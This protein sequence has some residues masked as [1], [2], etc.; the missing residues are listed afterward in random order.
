MSNGRDCDATRRPSHAPW[1]GDDV[2]RLEEGIGIVKG[3]AH[4]HKDQIGEPGTFGNGKD[5]IQN[6]IASQVAIE[7]LFAGHAEVTTHFAP[8]LRG[9]TQRGTF[10]IGNVD[11][12]DQFSGRGAEQIFDGAIDRD[13]SFCR[14][15]NSDGVVLGK[16][17]AMSLG[18]VAH[19]CDVTHALFVYPLCY[20]LG[21]EARHGKG[22]Y[23]VLEFGEGFAE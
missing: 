22:S 4:T 18:K 23:D 8:H 7:A 3:F 1:R 15:G 13:R 9:Y 2:E 12:L 16:Q 19:L 11:R 21:S 20:L 6:L 14:I 10:A 5:L 17:G